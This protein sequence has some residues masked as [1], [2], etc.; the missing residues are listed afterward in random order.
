MKK[1]LRNPNP[2]QPY[3]I[4]DLDDA[5][6]RYPGLSNEEIVALPKEDLYK[7]DILAFCPTKQKGA[8][9]LLSLVKGDWSKMTALNETHVIRN[10]LFLVDKWDPAKEETKQLHEIDI[11]NKVESLRKISYIANLANDMSEI[12]RRENIGA[13]RI[14]ITD[15]KWN[16]KFAELVA[17]VGENFK[18]PT[19]HD[20]ELGRWYNNERKRTFTTARADRMQSMKAIKS[21]LYNKT[22]LRKQLGSDD[23]MKVKKMISELKK[24][25]A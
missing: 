22:R 8:G 4:F 23:T 3:V 7:V 12:T 21:I 2:P 13:T 11:E 10:G 19:T 1:A 15:K 9:S 20:S 18:L 6:R 14:S 16:A 5:R 17:Y 25:I 24:S